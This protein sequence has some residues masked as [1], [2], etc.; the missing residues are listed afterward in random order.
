MKKRIDL[1]AGAIVIIR[2][3]MKLRVVP[4]QYRHLKLEVI[5]PS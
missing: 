2:L 5:V 1:E 3:E 4:T